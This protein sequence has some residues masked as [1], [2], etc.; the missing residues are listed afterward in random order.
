MFTPRYFKL[1]KG[2]EQQAR[3]IYLGVCAVCVLLGLCDYFVMKET[4]FSCVSHFVVRFLG[5]SYCVLGYAK[6]YK[7]KKFKGHK[8]LRWCALLIVSYYCILGIVLYFTRQIGIY[9]PG[10]VLGVLALMVSVTAV[11]NGYQ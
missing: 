2:K 7:V 11:R 9:M 6:C 8:V 10:L 3:K 1:E 4:I 5:V